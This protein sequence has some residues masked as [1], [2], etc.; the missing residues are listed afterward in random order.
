MLFLS[1]FIDSNLISHP[2]LDPGS[3]HQRYEMLNQARL[4][5]GQ[6]QHD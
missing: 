3:Q 4:P 6:V 2:G 1:V 5:D